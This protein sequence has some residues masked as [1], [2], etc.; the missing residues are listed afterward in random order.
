MAEEGLF[1]LLAEK[2]R[3]ALGGLA[4]L[5]RFVARQ[6][7]DQERTIGFSD[8]LP[9]LFGSGA[10]HVAA[11]RDAGLIAMQ[12]SGPARSLFVRQA[13]GLADR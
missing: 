7:A 4:V 10:L 11:A 13:T 5:E 2:N 12:L 3:E 1:E 9:R 8:L 6:R